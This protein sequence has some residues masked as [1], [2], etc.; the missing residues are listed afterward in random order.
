MS[1]ASDYLEGQIGTHLLRTGSWA[2]P[3]TIYVALFTTLPAEDGTGGVEVSGGSYARVLHGPSDAAWSAPT[4]GNGEHA[5]AS[6][7]VFPSPTGNWGNV[8]GFALYD[9]PT[10]GSFLVGAALAAARNIL[11][12]DPA[13]NFPTNTLKVVIG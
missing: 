3:S 7:V 4:A 13:P 10:A 11:S 9:D 6:N 12:G 1:N 5:N 2:K 8:V